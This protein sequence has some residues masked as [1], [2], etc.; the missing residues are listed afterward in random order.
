[1]YEPYRFRSVS[2]TVATALAFVAFLLSAAPV[3][4]ADGVSEQI[5]Q[6]NQALRQAEKLLHD[7]KAADASKEL[8]AADELIKKIAAAEPTNLKLVQLKIKYEKIKKDV[9][10]RL[11]KEETPKEESPKAGKQPDAPRVELP[12]AAREALHDVKKTRS[13]IEHAYSMIETSKTTEI[14][15]PV[16]AHYADVEKAI[17]ELK[18][19]LQTARDLA[20]EKGVTSHPDLDEAQAYLDAA[21]ERLAQVKADM[22][23]FKSDQAADE[24]AAQDREKEKKASA[25]Q[26]HGRM[27][28]DWKALSAVCTEYQQSFQ[29]ESEMK[30]RGADAIPAWQD[31]KKRF[32]PI[33]DQFRK[34]YGDEARLVNEAFT[35]VPK[36]EGVEMDAWM[37]A[38]LAYDLDMAQCEKRFAEAAARWGEDAWRTTSM[39][40]LDNQ[41]KLELKYQR[42]EDALRYYKLAAQWDPAGSYADAVRKSEAAVKEALPLW[43]DVLKKLTWPGHNPDFAGPGDA[44]EI[45]RAALEFLRKN[46]KWSKPEYD[47]EHVP[48]AACV[49]GKGWDVWKRAPL[50]QE[51][52]QYSV[53]VLVAFTGQAD[54]DLVYVYHMVFYTDEFAGVKPGLPLHYA[55]S[56]QYAKFRMLKESVP[57]TK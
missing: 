44:N 23:K 19:Q 3:A 54:S 12:R 16:E 40:K 22:A 35:D 48:F 8:E 43:K 46:P 10:K 56:K 36:P 29:S 1:M 27:M 39:I 51:P 15:K 21:P 26:S 9:K 38:N 47:D 17:G 20:A 25:A 42:A 37:A 5:K 6:A 41:E 50:T 57:E 32:E 11:P 30:K 18:T 13:G 52:T 34:R 2:Y 33:R 53:D 31:W 4:R 14:S 55:N 28:E 45:A 24:Q 49:E 7:G